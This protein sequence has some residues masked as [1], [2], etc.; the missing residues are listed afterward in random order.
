MVLD[1]QYWAGLVELWAGGSGW[2]ELRARTSVDE[3]DIARLLRRVCEFLSQV[4]DVPHLSAPLYK[5]ARAA[6]DALDRPPISDL[7]A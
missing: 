5:S 6:R 4:G 7:M 3:G 1:T 2:D